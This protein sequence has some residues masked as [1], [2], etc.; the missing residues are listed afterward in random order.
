[1]SD[2]QERLKAIKLNLKSSADKSEA[3]LD[4]IKKK[5]DRDDLLDLGSGSDDSGSLSGED[6]AKGLLL[7]DSCDMEFESRSTLGSTTTADSRKRKGL[8]SE[9]MQVESNDGGRRNRQSFE[10]GGRGGS[11][12]NKTL[13]KT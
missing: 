2:F 3:K 6:E 1:M 12:G 10:F 4:K 11:S 7:N 9:A 5:A 13:S 8:S